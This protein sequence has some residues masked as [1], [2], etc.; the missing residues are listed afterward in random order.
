M[1]SLEIQFP[2]DKTGAHETLRGSDGRAN[3]SARS[4]SRAYYNSRD[5]E[6][7]FALAFLMTLADTDE[8]FVAWRNASATMDLV[9]SSVDISVFEPVDVKFHVGTG[10]PAAGTI[11]TPGNMNQASSKAAPTDAAVSAMEGTTTTPLTGLTSTAVVAYRS[12]STAQE[13]IHIEFHDVVRLG[14]NGTF[15]GELE[16]ASTPGFV[17]GVIY[18]YYE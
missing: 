14:Q 1:S 7:T 3:V 2:N 18:G 17:L 11:I 13:G 9:I 16:A 5:E 4:D 12:I 8:D 10:T 15:F 6:L